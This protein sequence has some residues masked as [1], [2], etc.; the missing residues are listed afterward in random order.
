MGFFSKL[1]KG[2]KSVFNGILKIFEPILK[3]ISK[4]LSSGLGKAIMIGISVF[5]L[6][7]S[8]LAGAQGFMGA[9]GGFID[10]FM[11]GGKDFMSSLFGTGAADEAGATVAESAGD[12]ITEGANVAGETAAQSMLETGATAELGGSS[13]MLSE[14]AGSAMGPAAGA[15]TVGE[16]AKMT[17]EVAGGNW[18][19]KAATAAKDFATSD[20]GGNIIGKM[21]EG[22]GSGMIAKDRQ[23]FDSRVERQFA[24]PNDPGV[25]ALRN[26]D[27]SVTA[28]N[29][30]AAGK[31]TARTT[32][33]VRN[34]TPTV[35]Y[36]RPA[37]VGG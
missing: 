19:S 33:S 31:S 37:P 29:A 26:H 15:T 1:W 22:V 20:G 13:G 7:T 35:R 12:L 32:A 28:P 8:L 34:Q 23:E 14:A 10:K 4:F 36:A 27:Y 11:A 21:I 2:V 18:L 25:Q 30:Q 24:D 9:S 16:A 6:G 3:P 17:N 5:T